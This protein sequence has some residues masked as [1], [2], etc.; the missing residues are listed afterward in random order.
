MIDIAKLD[1][2][3]IE[4]ELPNR[5]SLSLG[6]FLLSIYTLFDPRVMRELLTVWVAAYRHITKK[7]NSND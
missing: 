2:E 7:A 4:R 6:T 5:F 3:L 1:I